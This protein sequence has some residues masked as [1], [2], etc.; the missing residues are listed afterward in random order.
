MQEKKK[1]QVEKINGKTKMHLYFW[2]IGFTTGD[3][4]K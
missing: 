4:H 3:P 1:Q 2:D